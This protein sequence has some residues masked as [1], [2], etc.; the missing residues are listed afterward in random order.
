MM[1]PI[2]AFVYENNAMKKIL[3][4]AVILTLSFPMLSCAASFDCSK[5]ASTTEKMIC[6]DPAISKLDEQLAAAYK[7][8]SDAATDKDA[9]KTQQR[10]WLKQ[11]RNLCGDTTCLTQTYQNRIAELLKPNVETSVAA[12]SIPATTKAVTKPRYKTTTGQQFELCRNYCALLSRTEEASIYDCGLRHPFDD[13]AKQQG[14]KEIPW[15][16][17]NIQEYKEL[18]FNKIAY[19]TLEPTE[20]DM[21]ESRS[22]FEKNF[23]EPGNM[24]LW[25]AAFDLNLDG[26]K[27][28]VFRMT[29]RHCLDHTAFIVPDEKNLDTKTSLR[30]V[31]PDPFFYEGRAY[32]Q[33]GGGISESYGGS[34]SFVRQRTLCDCTLI[35]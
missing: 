18:M 34:G 24:R 11:N 13:I 1:K 23:N 4:P 30:E 33:N 31:A 8:A 3:L 27:D 20:K 16:E 19:H 9:L 14:F 17:L 32:I 15:K 5:A 2:I 28:N 12:S 35:D 21:Q 25:K 22:W 6:N 7:T 10:D 29:T 26:E